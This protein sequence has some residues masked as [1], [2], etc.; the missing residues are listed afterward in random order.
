MCPSPIPFARFERIF[1]PERVP[2]T[3]K[4]L[5]KIR[6]KLKELGKNFMYLTSVP[7]KKNGVLESRASHLIPILKKI[8]TYRSLESVNLEHELTEMCQL[9]ET[10]Q[11]NKILFHSLGMCHALVQACVSVDAVGHPVLPLS[12][13]KLATLALSSSITLDENIEYLL[14][15]SDIPLIELIEVTDRIA[16][17][18]H[19]SVDLILDVASNLLQIITI[20]LSRTPSCDSVLHVK[21]MIVT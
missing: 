8:H 5:K 14:C 18:C 6:Q 21:D 3:R 11:E 7:T 13:I 9:L 16:S 1:S 10:D 12:T 20:C 2:A 17:F 4:K 19:P 15:H